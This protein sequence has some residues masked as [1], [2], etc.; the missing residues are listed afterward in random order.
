MLHPNLSLDSIYIYTCAGGEAQPQARRDGHLQFGAGSRNPPRRRAARDRGPPTRYVDCPHTT[1]V[2]SVS[3]GRRPN[4]LSA[5][6]PHSLPGC[7]LLGEAES[8]NAARHDVSCAQSCHM[9]A[10]L[11]LLRGQ[12]RPH[13]NYDARLT[14]FRGGGHLGTV[15]PLLNEMYESSGEKRHVDTGT[16]E[17]SHPVDS[18]SHARRGP[19]TKARPPTSRASLCL[20][21]RPPR[22]R[23]RKLRLRIRRRRPL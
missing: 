12:V 6:K 21:P 8:Q 10:L 13:T 17:G 5:S 19:P 14:L 7:W 3:C 9:R 15:G 23:P 18:N 22:T 2:V 1:R 11:P 16:V 20:R 4:R